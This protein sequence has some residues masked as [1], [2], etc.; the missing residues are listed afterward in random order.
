MFGVSKRFSHPKQKQ[1]P[2]ENIA[3][4]RFINKH[5]TAKNIDFVESPL[6]KNID[7]IVYADLYGLIIKTKFIKNMKK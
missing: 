6:A 1:T 7:S 4:W 2:N 5:S 3:F